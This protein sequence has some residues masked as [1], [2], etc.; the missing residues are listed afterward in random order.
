MENKKVLLIAPLFFNYYQHIKDGL[1]ALGYQVDFICD[2]PSNSNVSKAFARIN[3]RF[4]KGQTDKYY[5][6]TV[7]PLIAENRYDYV[8]VIAGMTFAFLKGHLSHL[9]QAQ[10]EAKFIAYFWDALKNLNYVDDF[11]P[12]FD[13]VYSF[14]RNDC[15]QRENFEFLP[16]F[17][18]DNY[19]QIQAETPKYDCCYVGTAHPKKFA[20]INQMVERLQEVMPKQFIYHYMPSRLKFWFH[21]FSAK[22]Y[23]GVRYSSF[24]NQKLSAE[25]TAQTVASSKIVLDA[26]QA[27]QLGL[28]MRTFECLAAKRKLITTNQDIVNYDFYR[29]E[30]IYVYNGTFDFNDVFFTAEYSPLAQEIYQKYSLQ[31]WLITL[32]A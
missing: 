21:K 22:E 25:Q 4:I 29:P 3:K 20:F 28:T 5:K 8:L 1:I 10:K 6:N 31:N 7:C 27:G 30:N 24:Q 23:R 12:Y 15:A 14:D 9:R 17:Y 16:L 19:A 32:L 26:P 2:A 13:K 11:L 18:T